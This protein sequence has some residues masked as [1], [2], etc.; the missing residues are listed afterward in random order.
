ELAG[1]LERHL[2]N[3]PVLAG[4]AGPRYR[5]AKLAQRH[6]GL[7]GTI[8]VAM[9]TMMVGLIIITGLYLENR[10][11]R[12]LLE[13]QREHVQLSAD[14]YQLE[15]LIQ[16]A[17]EIVPGRPEQIPQ[18]EAWIRLAESVVVRRLP[19]HRSRLA[20]LRGADVTATP[21]DEDRL[22][23]E[24]LAELVPKLERFASP[25]GTP[26]DVRARLAFPPA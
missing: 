11:A 12:R 4:P 2:R 1:D 14:A 8:A 23:E 15:H 3:E 19:H 10:R 9:F 24:I 18:L 21:R 13:D 20:E 17:D 16:Q 26:A 6:R 5:L 7:I 25:T 22:D